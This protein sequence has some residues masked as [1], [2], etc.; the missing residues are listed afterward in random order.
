MTV[1]Q[2]TR[3]PSILLISVALL[4]AADQTWKDKQ[5]A[6][7]TDDD[8]KQILSNSPWA[9][10]VTPTVSRSSN[11]GQRRSRGMGQGGRNGG[12][13]MGGGG[14]GM[15]IPGIG[16]MGRRGGMGGGS[17][18]GGYPRGNDDGTGTNSA[19]PVLTLRWES[20]LPVR[21]AELKVHDSNSP[22]VDDDHY[23]IA[24]YGVPNRMVNDNSQNLEDQLKKQ[25]VLKRD[26]KKDMKPSSVDVLQRED[27]AVIVYLFP[28]SKEITK[29]DR[30]ILLDAQIGRLKFGVDFYVEEM[31]YQGKREL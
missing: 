9:K 21:G 31:V 13:G 26:G 5:I 4:A 30:R 19:P 28:R 10:A 25:T 14:I 23:A 2:F 3:Q 18:G 24:V 20:A 27:G 11:D 17:G 8:V 12:G 16:G 29:E 7:W 22:I 6:E 15:G 1:M